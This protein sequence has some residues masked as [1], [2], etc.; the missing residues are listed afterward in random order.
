MIID[1]HAHLSA[2][3]EL[4]AYKS[5]L[6]SS[7]GSHGRGGVHVSDDQLRDAVEKDKQGRHT[8]HMEY[9]DSLGTDMQ[10]V[11]PR[12]YQLMHSEKPAKIV[13]WF[14]E[15]CNN[16][17]YR[18]TQIYPDRFFGIAG[19][20]EPAGEPITYAVRELER[21]VKELG[22]K[23]C[24]LNPDPY[25]NTGKQPPAMGDK[26]WYPLYEKLC[27]LDVP[28]HIHGTGS[29]ADREPYTLQFI[30]E[31][32]TTVFGLV[33]STVFDDF[34]NLKIIVSHGGGAMPFQIGRFEAGTI[35]RG[36]KDPAQLFSSRMKKLY[37]DT[38]LYTPEAVEFL[39]KVIGPEKC[40][41]GS[42]C[43]GTGSQIDPRTRRPLDDVAPSIQNISW[44]S[45]KD[46]QAVLCDNAVKL[47]RLDVKAGAKSRGRA[48]AA[49]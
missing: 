14:A 22:F 9:I 16:L 38:V 13:Q 49:E 20:P 26:Y 35:R 45:D 28:A 2:P 27:E 19:L 39:I 12:P 44:L 37:Y 43:P 4:Y 46:K 15:E 29:K 30:N 31:E 40:L 5:V 10:A 41:F 33:N 11:S 1:A 23:G 47:F 7:R 8:A 17:I 34:P 48:K 6:L 32:T 36:A 25:E 3:A 42:E 24:L 21:C 18:Q